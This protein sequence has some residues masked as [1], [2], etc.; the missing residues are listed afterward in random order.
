MNQSLSIFCIWAELLR[1]RLLTRVAKQLLLD[2]KHRIEK[3]WVGTQ[4]GSG[5]P[6]LGPTREMGNQALALEQAKAAHEMKA[7]VRVPA[8]EMIEAKLEVVVDNPALRLVPQAGYP[9]SEVSLLRFFLRRRR[10]K[11]KNSRIAYRKSLKQVAL[12]NV[13]LSPSAKGNMLKRLLLRRLLLSHFLRYLVTVPFSSLGALR[14]RRRE[15]QRA[16]RKR[17]RHFT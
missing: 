7:R 8:Q 5:D 6:G 13:A 10:K 15:M 9:A 14:R 3:S 11:A 4:P 12:R 17:L 1:L 2:A 16:Q